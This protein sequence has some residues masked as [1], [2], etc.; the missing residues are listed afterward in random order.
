MALSKWSGLLTGL[1]GFGVALLGFLVARYFHFEAGVVTSIVG[2]LI[3]IG[4]FVVNR[5]WLERNASGRSGLD[6]VLPNRSWG[7]RETSPGDNLES[8]RQE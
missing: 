4:G 1:A 3:S 7:R 8:K 6:V 2:G 5:I